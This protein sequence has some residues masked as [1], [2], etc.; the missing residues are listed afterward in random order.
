M[1]EHMQAAAEAAGDRA[2]RARA[3]QDARVT[4]HFDELTAT[5]KAMG[6]AWAR[7]NWPWQ[8]TREQAQRY[9]GMQAYDAYRRSGHQWWMADYPS[10]IGTYEQAWITGWDAGLTDRESA[11]LDIAEGTTGGQ[12]EEMHE[13][14]HP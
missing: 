3:A 13:G 12:Q 5:A 11:A 2:D 6:Y 10:Y 14:M 8:E 9:A 4:Q 7:L 1:G